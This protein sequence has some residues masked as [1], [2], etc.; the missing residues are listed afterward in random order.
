MADEWFYVKD[1][2]KQ[3]PV[4]FVQLQSLAAQGHIAPGDMLLQG[5]TTKWTAA[6]SVQGLFPATPGD[7]PF[8]PPPEPAAPPP[9]SEAPPAAE[10]LEV[11]AQA[12]EA[13]Q[14]VRPH[15]GQLIFNLGATTIGGGALGLLGTGLMLISGYWYPLLVFSLFAAGVGG[16]VYFKAGNDLRKMKANVVDPSGEQQTQQGQFFALIGAV[17][18][19]VGIALGTIIII[20]TKLTRAS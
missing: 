8:G 13:T 3:G 1:K 20:V 4:T 15:Q 6:E 17:L 16:P 14:R 7:F 12:S 2:K 18:G 11:F 10:D 5:G 9:E 19:A